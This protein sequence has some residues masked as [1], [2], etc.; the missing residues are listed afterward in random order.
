[1]SIIAAS[2]AMGAAAVP[3]AQDDGVSGVAGAPA[4]ASAVPGLD[5]AAAPPKAAPSA[6]A[7]TEGTGAPPSAVAESEGAEEDQ[8]VFEEGTTTAQTLDSE[9]EEDSPA[10]GAEE[11]DETASAGAEADAAGAEAD[12]AALDGAADIYVGNWLGRRGKEKCNAH[13]YADVII[14]NSAQ[15]LICTEVDLEFVEALRNPAASQ[16]AHSVPARVRQSTPAVAGPGKSV[17]EREENLRAW[18]VAHTETPKTHNH[19]LV[20][21]AHPSLAEQCV[22]LEHKTLHHRDKPNKAGN[23]TQCVSRFLC[24]EISFHKPVGGM[25]KVRVMSVHIHHMV[26]KK[27]ID[28]QNS[29]QFSNVLA[30]TVSRRNSKGSSGAAAGSSKKNICQQREQERQS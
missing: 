13:I 30:E 9:V 11:E 15:I 6:V 4:E 3:A 23:M 20:I 25:R 19:A 16:Y 7:E 2:S 24:A 26:A 28:Q 10:P 18:K 14:R 17:P 22:A 29:Q 12:A 27:V 21:A 8:A 1:M 5:E